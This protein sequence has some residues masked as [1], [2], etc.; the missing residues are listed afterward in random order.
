M[1][2]HLVIGGCG[3]IGSNLVK[4]LLKGKKN[5][6]TVIDNLSRKGSEKLKNLFIKNKNYK[7]YK[8]DIRDQKKVNSF[9]KK[10]KFNNIYLLAGQVAVTTSIVNPLLDFQS[11]LVGTFNILEA[12]RKFNKNAILLY[13]ST[14][15][16]YGKLEN[17]KIKLK[18]NEY[19]YCR[20]KNGID[21]KNNINFVTPYGCSKGAADLYCQDYAKTY[22]LK[23]I[24]MRQSCIYGPMQLGLEDQGWVAWLS[25]AALKKRKI[26][27][28]GN[29]KQVRD[30]LYV[31]DLVSAYILAMKSYKKTSGKVYNIGGG[32]KYK[33]SILNYIFL[34]EKILGKKISFN[35]DKERTGD[36]KVFVSDNTRAFKDF[37]WKPSTSVEDGVRKMITWLKDQKNIINI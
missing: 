24:V 28:F 32:K 26:T 1:K 36:Q 15:K 19:M 29:G 37:T 16:V 14:N 3:F 22:G 33:I 27:I 7:F 11:N 17:I 34:L 9:F 18:K 6:V 31:E 8:L 25:I 13:S 20:K 23:T 2:N 10:E 12:I 5:K 30:L 4:R 21:E 35:F